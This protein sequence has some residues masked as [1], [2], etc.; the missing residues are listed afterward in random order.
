MTDFQIFTQQIQ[1]ACE[2]LSCA[3]RKPLQRHMIAFLI[4]SYKIGFVIN[5]IYANKKHSR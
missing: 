1:L 5:I 3:D 2:E 4:L